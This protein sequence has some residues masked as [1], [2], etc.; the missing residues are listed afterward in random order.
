ME[1]VN[2]ATVRNPKT[3]KQIK[4]GRLSFRQL[5]DNYVYDFDNN[6]FVFGPKMENH[7]VK[8]PESN[9]RIKLYG[10]KFFQLVQRYPYDTNT[11]QFIDTTN[12]DLS[13]VQKIKVNNPESGRQIVVNGPTF[14]K[15]LTKYP[16]NSESNEFIVPPG[17]PHKT[18]ST[19]S[20]DKRI[21]QVN[22][23]YLV[24]N[25]SVLRDLAKQLV[26]IERS[27]YDEVKESKYLKMTIFNNINS[28]NKIYECLDTTYQSENKAFKINIVF[29][30]ITEKEGDIRL[31]KPGR[32][33]FFNEP[34]VI[35]NGEDLKDLKNNINQESIVDSLT[36]QFPDSHTTLIGVYAM[37][38]KITRLDFPIGS[39]IVLPQYIKG[40]QYII[41]LEDVNNNNMCFWSCMAL[42]N[43]CRKDRYIKKANTLFTE[44][45]NGRKTRIPTDY[46]G[47][48]YVNELSQYEKFD[49]KHAIN[50]ISYYE[51]ETI[52]YIRKSSFNET[53]IPIY[54]NLYLDHFSYIT[55][56][57]Q[58]AKVYLCK[59]CSMKFRNNYDMQRHF[60]SCTLEQKDVFN[61]FPKLWEKAR[62][63]IVDLTD[64]HDINMDFKYDYLIT[65]DL[66]SINHKMI[67]MV[68]EK[69]TYVGKHIPVSVS[70]ATNVPGFEEEKF[71]LSENPK[72]ITTLMF[73]YFDK[74]ALKAKELMINKMQPLLNH[75]STEAKSLAKVQSYCSVIPI[76]GFNSGFYDIN[77]L[78]NEGFIN[79]IMIRDPRPFVLKDGNKYKVIKTKDFMFLDQM[80]YCAAGTSLSSFIKG[81]DIDEQ[82]GWFPYE[83]FDSYDKLD[84]PVKNLK[85]TDFYSSLK[86]ENITHANFNKL[87]E[88]CDKYNLILV[89]DLLKWYNNLDVRP[90]L[91]ACLKQ[92]EFFYTFKLDMYKDAFSLPALSENILYQFQLNGFEDYLKQKPEIP[93]NVLRLNN[94]EIE[95]RIFGYR[96]QDLESD[97][98]PSR[99]VTIEDIRHI[100]KRENYCCFYC[101]Y[102]LQRNTWSLDRI[103]CCK[104]HIKDNCI[105]ACMGC[106]KARSNKIFKQFY[107]HKALLRWEKDHPMIWL[108]GEENKDTFYKFKQNITGGASIVFHRYHEKDKTQIT[109]TH[110]DMDKKEWY[111]DKEGKTVKKIVGYDANALYLYCLG[112][113]M[114]CGKLYWKEIDDWIK[115][116]EEVIT[117]KFFGFLEVDIEVPE[118]K[119]DYF[120]EMCPIFINKE[121]SEDV[122]G[123]YT[124][125]LLKKL[126]RKP[127]KSRKLITV[128]KAE[129][130]L[131]KSTRL[132][133]L[134]NHGC[135]VSKLHGVIEAKRGKVFKGFMDWVSNERRKGDTDLKYKIIA[136]GAKLVGNS[137]F[138]RTGMDKNKHKRVKYCNEVQFNKA[139]NNYFYYDSEEYNGVYEVIKRSKTVLQNMPIQIACSVF[140]DS[141]LRML[142]FYYDCIDKYLDRSDF[143]YIEMDTDSAYMAVTDNIENIVKPE[144][145]QEFE[146]DKHNWFPRNEHMK[147]DKRTPGLFK[148]EYEGIGMVALCSK[149]YYVWGSKNKVSSK[150]LQK[151]RNNEVLNKD[152][153]LQC[154]FNSETVNGINKGFRFESKTIKTYEQTKIGLSPIYSKGIVMDDGIHIRPLS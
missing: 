68:G 41:S 122:C 117:D 2:A 72:E 152:K 19:N 8:S 93:K 151:H 35:K 79:E 20:K 37:A 18:A 1:T 109:R 21:S 24:I 44:F 75:L 4:I 85:I 48:D 74:I 82:K 121:Y 101:W 61:K 38:V 6:Q 138:G 148:I 66:E 135:I 143:Q 96:K 50:I 103:D 134:L 77:L 51:D 28:L 91:K 116:R 154:L 133:W 16:Y 58:L 86:D 30:Y 80:N 46:V 78:S 36:R 87:M 95:K 31:I 89:K 83:W 42:A 27:A 64:L 104:A 113:E 132:R 97:R 9:K 29:G 149:T 98:D 120:G 124:K 128:L 127:T 5:L 45:Y 92:K 49:T 7:H 56:L 105:A 106:N 34:R 119:W 67:Q 111:Y 145:K 71:I 17:A 54:L 59:R 126:G 39:K 26:S 102:P 123:E 139:K 12:K 136:E 141:K 52:S 142:Q 146:K 47:F 14:K 62:N 118:D 70:I 22:D 43:G 11:N 55:D 115:Y 107:R 23:E 100:L 76:V 110:Y 131:I 112:E 84:Y 108:F 33:Y 94:N 137:A 63:L 3:G 25:E 65:F 60:D 57:Q 153:Y 88:I 40:C 144:L 147:I 90:M 150:G 15:L 81:Y 13:Q 99:N 125:D 129:K 114:P 69:L 53:R 140:D 73:E 10:P 32:N 130:I